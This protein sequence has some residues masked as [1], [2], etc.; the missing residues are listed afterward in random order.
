MAFMTKLYFSWSRATDLVIRGQSS[1]IWETKKARPSEE[2][3]LV[4]RGRNQSLAPGSTS[5]DC[6]LDLG[7]R[8]DKWCSKKLA[9][10]LQPSSADL[11]E[12]VLIARNSFLS[13]FCI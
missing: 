9:P 7:N 1:K 12:T 5:L 13:V 2:S 11:T 6:Q 10:V 4:V 8:E 3:Q